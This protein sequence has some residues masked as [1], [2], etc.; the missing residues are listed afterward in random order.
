MIVAKQ[1]LLVNTVSCIPCR[2]GATILKPPPVDINHKICQNVRLQTDIQV[3]RSGPTQDKL[4]RVGLR[5]RDKV[6]TAKYLTAFYGI[7][8]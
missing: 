1:S 7:A 8:I 2:Q 5:P 4:L 3:F 6:S